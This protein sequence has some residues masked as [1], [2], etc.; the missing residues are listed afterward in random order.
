MASW[1]PI[2]LE[3]QGDFLAEKL[4][5]NNLSKCFR[6]RHD[7]LS[8]VCCASHTLDHSVLLSASLRQ[9]VEFSHIN[10]ESRR[11]GHYI[12]SSLLVGGSTR[13]QIQVLWLVNSGT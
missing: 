6:G 10:Q 1:L 13:T 5:Q 7:S 4:S 9:I 11:L 8:A 3:P 12:T 2:P